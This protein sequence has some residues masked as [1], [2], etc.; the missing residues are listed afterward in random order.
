VAVEVVILLAL[1]AQAEAGKVVLVTMG[2]KQTAPQTQAAA[3]AAQAR[4]AA[5]A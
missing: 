5:P 3:Q 4:P 2:A 1:L